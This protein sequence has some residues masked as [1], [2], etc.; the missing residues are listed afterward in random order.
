MR[1]LRWPQPPLRS[2]VAFR[3]V[4]DLKQGSASLGLDSSHLML[5]A[6]GAVGLGQADEGGHTQETLM[7][8]ELCA[9]MV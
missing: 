9:F 2:R 8:A 4:E 1:N 5:P 3:A 6:N 7:L